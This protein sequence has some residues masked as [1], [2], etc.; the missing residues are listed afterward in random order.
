MPLVPIRWSGPITLLAKRGHRHLQTQKLAMVVIT[1]KAEAHSC[2]ISLSHSLLNLTLTLSGYSCTLTRSNCTPPPGHRLVSPPASPVPKCLTS[3]LKWIGF[4]CVNGPLL[5]VRGNQ[6]EFPRHL[7][8]ALTS[9]VSM[10]QSRGRDDFEGLVQAPQA[11]PAP[12]SMSLRAVY[13]AV[14]HRSVHES[15][16]TACALG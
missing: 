7:P 6:N 5:L 15:G 13:Q 12:R 1:Q 3:N 8:T 4:Q 14:D 10:T 16:A 11:P 9:A 2:S